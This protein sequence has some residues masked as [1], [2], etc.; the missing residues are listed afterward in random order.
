[1]A[2][3]PE[4]YQEAQ[5][6]AEASVYAYQKCGATGDSRELESARWQQAQGQLH[7][8]LALAAATAL[9]AHAGHDWDGWYAAAGEPPRI[10]GQP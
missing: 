7:A 5:T 8:T 3:G 4:H 9:T 10:T 2:T 1:M 6:F